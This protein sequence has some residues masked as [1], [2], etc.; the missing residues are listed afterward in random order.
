MKVEKKFSVENRVPD[1]MNSVEELLYL[2]LKIFDM[3]T[4]NTKLIKF[5]AI[6]GIGNQTY[7]NF[8]NG[9]NVGGSKLF[10]DFF[11]KLGLVDPNIYEEIRYRLENENINLLQM[12]M[13]YQTVYN[14]RKKKRRK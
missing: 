7:Y 9:K 2:F 12:E 4:V 11:I 5:L 14:F 13:G 8:L 1:K 6:P 3:F 10:L